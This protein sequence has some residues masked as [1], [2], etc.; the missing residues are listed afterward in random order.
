MA[1]VITKSQLFQ[2]QKVLYKQHNDFSPILYHTRNPNQLR[3]GYYCHQ[4]Q[5]ASRCGFSLNKYVYFAINAFI[6]IIAIEFVSNFLIMFKWCTIFKFTLHYFRFYNYVDRVASTLPTRITHTSKLT[7]PSW[8]RNCLAHC[9]YNSKELDSKETRK[10]AYCCQRVYETE[11]ILYAVCL[12][13]PI[14]G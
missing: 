10:R 1:S 11:T 5:C 14:V 8:T 6:I 12:F 2:I 7:K 9:S 4:F 3:Y 13:T